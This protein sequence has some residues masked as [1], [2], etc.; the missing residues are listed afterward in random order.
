MGGAPGAPG[1]SS[2]SGGSDST[3]TSG[4]SGSASADS[5]NGSSGQ[6]DNA[7]GGMR[8]GFSQAVDYVSTIDATV[9]L[10][11]VGQLILIGLGLTLISALV[12]IIFVMRYEPLQ[13]LADRS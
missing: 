13:I 8:G 4:D 11:V 9:N 2:D 7:P 10:K 3:G 6:P 12:G 5:S 1:S